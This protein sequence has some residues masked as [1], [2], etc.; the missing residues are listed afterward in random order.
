MGLFGGAIATAAF[1][2]LIRAAKSKDRSR[3]P[4]AIVR[5]VGLVVFLTVPAAIIAIILRGYI[6]RL[7]FGFGDQVTADALGWLAL[8]IVAQS[9]F[10]LIARV[11][12]SLEDTRTPL[13]ASLG[14]IVINIILSI[15]LGKLY[16]VSGLAMALS[17]TTTLELIVL[18]LL[19]RRKIGPYGLGSIFKQGIRVTSASL[20][21]GAAMYG[22][23]RQVLPLLRGDIGFMVVGT[24][25]AIIS[26]GGLIV[27]LLMARLLRIGETDVAFRSLE[28]LKNKWPKLH[29]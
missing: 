9:V 24:K 18:M 20:I 21:M 12:Y 23:V 5:N 1:P 19:L 15:I 8:S 13:F 10:F 2:G 25:F 14:A 28:K 27:Y 7:L 6:V 29:G 26:A 4:S 16:G 3:L 11:F 22:L 17:I